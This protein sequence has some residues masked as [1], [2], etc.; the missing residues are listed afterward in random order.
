MAKKL[1]NPKLVE[2]L[3]LIIAPDGCFTNILTLR[4]AHP[5]QGGM[6]MS[7]LGPKND[8][9]LCMDK[10]WKKMNNCRN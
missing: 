9:A 1:L 2:S 3:A 8:W 10:H 7:G 6:S 4:L 5:T